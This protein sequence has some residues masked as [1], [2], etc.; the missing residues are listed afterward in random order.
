MKEF[1]IGLFLFS[2][3]LVLMIIFLNL[4][5]DR[6]GKNNVIPEDFESEISEGLDHYIDKF[7]RDL[8][9][10]G[11]FPSRPKYFKVVF[12]ELDEEKETSHVHGYSS[13]YNNDLTV[14]IYINKRSWESFSKPQRYYLIYHEL[15]HDILNLDD[16]S[17]DEGNYGKIMYPSI[18]KYSDLGMN[19]FI[20]N[21][22]SLFES[23]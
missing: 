12:A 10:Y 22:K 14:E 9:V 7:Y 3:L 4:D 5:E 2:I 13:G 8:G 6:I 19:D 1:K 16:L 21:M 23:L 15:S 17:D 20:V 18:S 11:H